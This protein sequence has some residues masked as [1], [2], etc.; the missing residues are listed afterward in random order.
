MQNGDLSVYF[1]DGESAFRV[2]PFPLTPPAVPFASE[3]PL[4]HLLAT[5]YE[6][7]DFIGRDG[8]LRDL[9][10]WRDHSVSDVGV[11]LIHGPGGQGKSRLAAE[12][13]RA[14]AAEGWE[15]RAARHRIDVPVS[16]PVETVVV[17]GLADRAASGNVGLLLVVDYADRWP[18]P[19]LVALLEDQTAEYPTG[20]PVRVLLL[21]RSA[22]MWWETLAH[23]FERVGLDAQEYALHPAAGDMGDRPELFARACERFGELLGVDDAELVSVPDD[24]AADA[25]GLILNLHMAALAG[26]DAHARGDT[27]PPSAAALSGYFLRREKAH[28][29]TLY[30]R[31]PH[32]GVPANRMARAVYCA[33]LLG[34]L[35]YDAAL[36]VVDRGGLG[37]PAQSPTALIDVHGEVYPSIGSR[38]VL[39]PLYPDRLGEDFLALQTPGHD[40]PGYR[41]DPWADGAPARLLLVQQELSG[42]Q[43]LAAHAVT[44]LIDVTLR[45]PHMGRFQF[46]PLLRDNPQLIA[47]ISSA[48]LSRL[49][50]IDDIDMGVLESIT[51]QL[52]EGRNTD[53]DV[54]AAAVTTRLVRHHLAGAEPE[55]AAVLHRWHSIRL[56][57]AG[58][59]DEATTAAA[60]SVEIYRGLVAGDRAHEADYA[61]ALVNFTVALEACERWDEALQ[62]AREAVGIRRRLS[63]RDLGSHEADLAEAMSNLAALQFRRGEAD[64][65][66]AVAQ[67]VV[68]SYERL[69]VDDPDKHANALAVANANL[70]MMLSESGRPDDALNYTQSAVAIFRSLA[71]KNRAAFSPHLAN[72]LS[73]LAAQLSQL[74]R[75]QEGLA[76][77]DEAFPVYQHLVDVNP[78][79]YEPGFARLLS[80]VS[81]DLRE[82]GQYSDAFAVACA[83]ADIYQ[84]LPSRSPD[85]FALVLAKSLSSLISDL[86]QQEERVDAA[87]AAE[88]AA[89][90]YRRLTE[91]DDRFTTQLATALA[92]VAAAQ[93]LA[94]YLDAALAAILE[95]LNLPTSFDPD[96]D[97]DGRK[98]RSI[99]DTVA[100]LLEKEE[101]WQEAAV[102]RRRLRG[103]S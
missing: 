37:L 59:Y 71:R 53:L 79:A 61:K 52:P 86:S 4:S 20:R 70:G 85:G 75:V 81:I 6:V 29:Q 90:T 11:M 38:T 93:L 77:A 5:R 27:V 84:R 39:E 44:R 60:Q 91:T 42:N 14:C 80:N 66:I 103:D 101:R 50:A 35:S 69:S 89:M 2:A 7:V 62:A 95:A 46:Y 63:E 28:W 92:R 16:V 72:S 24:L 96:E 100:D 23:Q 25:Y 12:F 87:T 19:D 83:A 45:W 10:A 9:T 47:G 78:S 74:G 8:E 55:K 82:E 30:E 13:A 51:T 18:Y 54:G 48:A 21:A 67:E 33:T 32:S 15:I 76:V 57:N 22:G 102:L 99:G 34:P 65:A 88:L 56:T 94:G 31:D 73:N 98:L 97:P 68:H 49:A 17:G 1:K 43:A 40:T 3:Q 58:R 26:V 41:A 64:E 36:A